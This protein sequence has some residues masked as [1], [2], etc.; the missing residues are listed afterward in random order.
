MILL[1]YMLYGQCIGYLVYV[2]IK[3]GKNSSLKWLKNCEV[4]ELPRIVK[5]WKKKNL[6]NCVCRLLDQ[7]VVT[8][9]QFMIMNS[10]QT[11]DQRC[12]CRQLGMLQALSTSS[13]G[14]IWRVTH[15]L[16]TGFVLNFENKVT[17]WAVKQSPRF[18]LIFWASS[19]CGEWQAL[20]FHCE[21]L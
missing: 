13:R 6:R 1:E 17:N 8:W 2:R 15:G 7:K 16:K 20:M 19:W 21:I 4:W 5:T 9:L 11:T 14:A 3:N 18:L 12:W 10:T